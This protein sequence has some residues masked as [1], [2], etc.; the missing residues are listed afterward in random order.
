MKLISYKVWGNPKSTFLDYVVAIFSLGRYSHSEIAFENGECFSISP[1]ENIGRLKVINYKNAEW[2]IINIPVSEEK[3]KEIYECA[4]L[5]ALGCIKY[6]YLGA[7]TSPL[8][9]CIQKET[10]IFCSEVVA[11]ILMSKG[12]V[13]LNRGCSYTPSR[14]HKQIKQIKG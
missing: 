7:L 13:N 11:D 10:R 14:L 2:D 8:R 9:L 5:V 4:Q 6:D 1:R 3:E 12:V